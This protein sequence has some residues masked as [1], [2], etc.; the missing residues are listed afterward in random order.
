[1]LLLGVDD[2]K[3]ER[4]ENVPGPAP[5]NEAKMCGVLSRAADKIEAST[6][7]RQKIKNTKLLFLL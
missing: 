4:T 2:S 1:V 6:K 3:A 5:Q 7:L